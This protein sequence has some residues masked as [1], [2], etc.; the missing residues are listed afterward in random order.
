MEAESICKCSYLPIQRNGSHHAN[1]ADTH[2]HMETGVSANDAAPVPQ[3]T[4][5]TVHAE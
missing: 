4:A 5:H 2:S 1:N 3:A